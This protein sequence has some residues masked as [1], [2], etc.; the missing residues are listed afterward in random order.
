M[1]GEKKTNDY[2]LRVGAILIIKMTYFVHVF[3]IISFKYQKHTHTHTM[4]SGCKVAYDVFM[5]K[6]SVQDTNIPYK[7]KQENNT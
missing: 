6:E 1:F 4:V 7:S 3:Q 2:F 5:L